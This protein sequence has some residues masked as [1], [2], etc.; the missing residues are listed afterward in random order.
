MSTTTVRI[1]QADGRL[2]EVRARVQDWIS[3]DGRQYSTADVPGLE[4]LLEVVD[5]DFD[6]PI[7]GG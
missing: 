1:K 6:G 2:V 3:G 5:R 4:H 7:Y